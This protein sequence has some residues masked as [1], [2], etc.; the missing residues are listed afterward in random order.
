[1]VSV[2]LFDCNVQ[3]LIVSCVKGLPCQQQQLGRAVA[4]AGKFDARLRVAEGQS[5]GRLSTVAV[6]SYS[7]PRR[8]SHPDEVL[9]ALGD[10]SIIAEYQLHLAIFH[11]GEPSSPDHVR[12][13]WY[14][15]HFGEK[16]WFI[17][18]RLTS[19]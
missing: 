10:S 8:F 15:S 19:L 1:M 9:T 2:P 11:E 3:C 12:T 14:P 5:K 16:V 13:F 4:V 17:W 6:D 18:W 7:K